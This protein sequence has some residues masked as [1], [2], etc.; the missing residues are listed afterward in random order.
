MKTATFSSPHPTWWTF[1][2][3]WVP[4]APRQVSRKP[5]YSKRKLFL[6]FSLGKYRKPAFTPTFSLA[7]NFESCT[8][9]KQLRQPT[10]HDDPASTSVWISGDI[11]RI[12]PRENHHVSLLF[13]VCSLRACCSAAASWISDVA[14]FCS[15]NSCVASPFK[16]IE[17]ITARFS[18]KSILVATTHTLRIAAECAHAGTCPWRSIVFVY[19][20][21]V[22]GFW[23]PI[24]DSTIQ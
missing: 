15:R 11:F 14:A 4:A 19:E 3:W 18:S 9:L 23:P 17:R 7:Q 2:R 20:R 6:P 8:S 21:F 12:G 13:A 10:G 5:R 24:P 1:R 16:P 22:M